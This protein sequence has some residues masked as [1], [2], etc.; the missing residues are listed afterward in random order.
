MEDLI[1]KTI[2]MR[3]RQQTKL[4]FQVKILEIGVSLRT[5]KTCINPITEQHKTTYSG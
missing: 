1:S 2:Y 3:K 4:R 5:L